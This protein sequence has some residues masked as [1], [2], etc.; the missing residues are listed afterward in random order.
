MIAAEPIVKPAAVTVPETVCDP[1]RARVEPS[2]VKLLSAL[3]EPVVPVSVR[4]LLFALF[5]INIPF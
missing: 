2:K 3:I 5:E 4:I 1:V